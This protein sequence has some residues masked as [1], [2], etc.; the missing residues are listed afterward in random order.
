[1]TDSI[2]NKNC[3]CDMRPARIILDLNDML[4]HLVT[5]H[6]AE[7]IIGAFISES[8]NQMTLAI[9]IPP[10]YNLSL[11]AL[12]PDRIVFHRAVS[13]YHS[14]I[15]LYLTYTPPSL[16]ISCPLLHRPLLV[17]SANNMSPPISNDDKLI[18]SVNITHFFLRRYVY[19]RHRI[20]TF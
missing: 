19:N 8:S 15:Y 6:T 2:P 9:G 14:L 18:S 4:C 5:Q 17:H 7:R 16:Q 20:V 11:Y 3:Y 1:M 12:F 10:R 13:S